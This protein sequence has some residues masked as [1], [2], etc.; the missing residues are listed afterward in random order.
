MPLKHFFATFLFFSYVA[1][2]QQETEGEIINFQDVKVI[3]L[4]KGLNDENDS[5]AS[6]LLYLGIILNEGLGAEVDKDSANNALIRS[7]ELG[8]LA[9][10]LYMVQNGATI[11]A[12]NDFKELTEYIAVVRNEMKNL[13][14]KF[15]RNSNEPEYPDSWNESHLEIYNLYSKLDKSLDKLLEEKAL[16]AKFIGENKW[17]VGDAFLHLSIDKE[18]NPDYSSISDSPSKYVL[19]GSWDYSIPHKSTTDNNVLSMSFVSKINHEND[20]N[21]FERRNSDNA[22]NYEKLFEHC[23]VKILL[24][25]D[26]LDEEIVAS[27]EFENYKAA[28]L[29]YQ[30]FAK[31]IDEQANIESIFFKYSVYF[32]LLIFIYFSLRKIIPI[33]RD[34]MLVANKSSKKVA[35]KLKENL[36]DFQS[37]IN[38]KRVKRKIEDI[39]FEEVIKQEIKNKCKA[40]SEI[41]EEFIREIVKR[42]VGSDNLIDLTQ[43]KEDIAQALKN[44]DYDKVK[45]LTDLA[46]KIKNIN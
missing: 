33:I 41:G 35:G 34:G 10:R 32:V 4:L 42:E 12:P 38:E 21:F 40:D 14:M 22:I 30:N 5:E 1:I 31:S 2:A 8:S 45:E 25:K 39:I 23:Y 3:E 26:E 18:E 20:C 36:D 6:H 24:K 43:L 46:E 15:Y 17:Q 44:G 28:G 9:A 7:S 19:V 13:G 16:K 37:S 27:I 11:V 29:A